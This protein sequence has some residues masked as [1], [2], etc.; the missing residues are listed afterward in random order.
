KR[1]IEEACDRPAEGAHQ[2]ALV[3]E[4]SKVYVSCKE[5][6]LSVF[7]R[8]RRKW[9]AGVPM[10]AP[11]VASGNGSGS[12]GVMPTAAGDRVV[13]IDNESNDLRVI[14]TRTDTEIDR[15]PLVSSPP[16][17]PKRSR[18]AQPKFSPDRPPPPRTPPA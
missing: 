3:P 14:D 10:R 13:V 16:S 18:L 11:G 1:E 17:N 5:G 2:M 15:V 12:E 7:V 8:V 6:D 9:V 4:E